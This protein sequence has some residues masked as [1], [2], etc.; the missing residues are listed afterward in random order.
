[1]WAHSCK[2]GR[3]SIRLSRTVELTGRPSDLRLNLFDKNQGYVQH[4]ELWF[5][6]SRVHQ[7]DGGYA[8]AQKLTAAA[9]RKLHAGFNEI[10][11]RAVKKAAPCRGFIGI[12][13]G[14]EGYFATDLFVGK[15]P[16]GTYQKELTSLNVI[17]FGNRGPS[18]VYHATF[19]FHFHRGFVVDEATDRREFEV[20]HQHT[21][22]NIS[23]TCGLK[24]D[25]E[26][27]IHCDLRNLAPGSHLDLWVQITH[28]PRYTPFTEDSVTF[29]YK[30]QLK[31]RDLGPLES[32][33]G[34]EG[35]TAWVMFCGE[36]SQRPECKALP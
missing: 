3:Q 10:E 29:G 11:V 22:G 4:F 25:V 14:L 23:G 24:S 9:R 16:P 13:F 27:V 2:P 36:L 33:W 6:G 19:D 31:D 21:E 5:N 30:I 32:K 28:W 17:R 15:G 7:H 34:N 18:W 35:A 20:A 12:H 8:I 1:M 26:A